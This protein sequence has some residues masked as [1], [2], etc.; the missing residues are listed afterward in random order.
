M[1]IFCKIINKE[2]PSDPIFEDENYLVINDLYPKSRI[3]MLIIPKK[4][5]DTI[6]DLEESDKD[7]IWWLFLLAKNIS[8][9]E[10]IVGYK[11][12]FNVGKEWWQEIMHIHLHFLAN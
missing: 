12:H 7:M 1:C 10:N 11:L 2:I 5:I 9:K 6:N 3:H 4:H 8:I